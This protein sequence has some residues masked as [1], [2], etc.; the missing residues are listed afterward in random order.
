MYPVCIVLLFAIVVAVLPFSDFLID[1]E[2]KHVQSNSTSH[3]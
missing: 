1:V 2:L 3:Y